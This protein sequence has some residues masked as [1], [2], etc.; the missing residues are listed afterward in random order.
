M[1]STLK[2]TKKTT[3]TILENKTYFETLENVRKNYQEKKNTTWLT[4]EKF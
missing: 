2:S 3:T 4:K 1:K